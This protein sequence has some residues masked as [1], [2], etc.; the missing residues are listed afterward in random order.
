MVL[1]LMVA[2]T[3][4]AA[5]AAANDTDP[6]VLLTAPQAILETESDNAEFET[7]YAEYLASRPNVTC[8]IEGQASGYK[9]VDFGLGALR[10]HDVAAGNATCASLDE[11]LRY[12][13]KLLITF[14][15]YDPT[16]RAWTDIAETQ[17]AC[18]TQSV[19]GQ[20]TLPCVNQYLYDFGHV[21]SGK[22]HRAKFE[23]LEPV[24]LLPKYSQPFVTAVDFQGPA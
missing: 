13:I 24:Q 7:A 22:L 15:Y 18:S 11:T 14:Q 20:G 4:M 10:Q 1:G 8:R 6:A 19:L 23:L 12:S 3:L 9:Q 16:V 5:P 2:V 21:A 17:A